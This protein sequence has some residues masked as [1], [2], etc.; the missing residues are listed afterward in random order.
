MDK[1]HPADKRRRGHRPGGRDQQDRA[2]EN[3]RVVTEIKEERSSSVQA[4]SLPQGTSSA[5]TLPAADEVEIEYYTAGP[6]AI[7]NEIADNRKSITISS[8]THYT[9]ILASTSI[10]DKPEPSIRLYHLETGEK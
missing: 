9:D 6:I 8:E 10:D 2:Q 7:E 4:F 1:D 3:R 5:L